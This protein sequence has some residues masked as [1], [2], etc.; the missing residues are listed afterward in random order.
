MVLNPIE[1]LWDIV[2]DGICNR[3]YPALNDLES[4]ITAVLK[5]YWCDARKVFSLIGRGW[6]LDQVNAI[7]PSV[8]PI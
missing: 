1:K 2:K 6:L 3:L 8:L 7:S 4:D 5:G